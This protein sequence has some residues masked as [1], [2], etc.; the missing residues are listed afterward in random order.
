MTLG[1]LI[2][3][4][5][6]VVLSTGRVDPFFVD[7]AD[8]ISELYGRKRVI[9]AREGTSEGRMLVGL[10]KHDDTE[11]EP[12]I[13]FTQEHDV[14]DALAGKKVII[15]STQGMNPSFGDDFDFRELYDKIASSFSGEP[16]KDLMLRLMRHGYIRSIPEASD[17]KISWADT[18]RENGADEIY[19]IEPC[20]FRQ[21][22][23]RGPWSHENKRIQE[24]GMAEK[25]KLD[26]ISPGLVLEAR[27]EANARVAAKLVYH[28][29]S[30]EDMTFTYRRNGVRLVTLDSVAVMASIIKNCEEA[31][32]AEG[33]P[34]KAVLQIPDQGAVGLGKAIF[35]ALGLDHLS[36]I[37]VED[38]I[39]EG[40]RTVGVKFGERSDNYQGCDNARVYCCDD[41][42]RS[43]A[44]MR[45]GLGSIV[46]GEGVPLRYIAIASHGDLRSP[47]T[48][49]NLSRYEEGGV[50]VPIDVYLTLSKP[51]VVNVCGP[52]LDSLT[53][54]N[55]GRL[56]GDVAVRCLL[57]GKKPNG[58]YTLETIAQHNLCRISPARAVYETWKPIGK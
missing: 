51:Q 19:L 40:A 52:L 23:D 2:D 12:M 6:I 35:E 4:R 5:D 14:G 28:P 58:L 3:K 53:V 22:S 44:T 54:V 31:A 13:R 41:L 24:R 33:Q 48:Q 57:N 9:I 32:L 15:V 45:V 25:K 1:R 11:A 49:K 10:H 47:T 46:G 42:I 30:L 26:G 17:A 50:S 21:A 16:E 8:R 38:K 34:R 43:A 56:M 27:K 39:K 55:Q 20:S 7:V 37:A 36:Y 29:H 18:A